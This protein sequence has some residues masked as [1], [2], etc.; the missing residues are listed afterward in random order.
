M[1]REA[2]HAFKYDGRHCLGRWLA[3]RM[4]QT[5]ARDFPC[6]TIEGVL[7]VPLHWVKAR[8]RG[9]N[10]AGALAQEVAARLDV[11]CETRI[12][13]RVRWTATQTR[14]NHRQRLGNVTEAFQAALPHPSMRAVLLVDDVLT[15]GATA[16]ACATALRRVG[17]ERVWVLAAARAV[18]E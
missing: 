13:R 16:H 2:I 17:V 8:L 11:P 12:L 6:H 14:L 1:M 15:S 5:A 9:M 18:L 10:P 4:A 7:P 3:A